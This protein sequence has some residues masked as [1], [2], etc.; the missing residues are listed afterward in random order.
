MFPSMCSVSS[1]YHLLNIKTVNSVHHSFCRYYS[2]CI[3]HVYNH[4][5]D[6]YIRKRTETH[7]LSW[8]SQGYHPVGRKGITIKI[9]RLWY[10]DTCLKC[11][12]CHDCCET[13]L[14]NIFSP[15]YFSSFIMFIMSKAKTWR[16]HC[17]R[18]TAVKP[19]N[20]THKVSRMFHDGFK[21]SFFYGGGDFY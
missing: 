16:H 19:L 3:S 4:K 17:S 10:V 13:F 20:I 21:V 11:I 6:V 15:Y 9:K 18:Q 12:L 14:Q 2:R 1:I 7:H 8:S 5:F